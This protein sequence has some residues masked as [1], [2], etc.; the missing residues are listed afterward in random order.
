MVN[1]LIDLSIDSL[2]D[3]LIHSESFVFYCMLCYSEML[4]YSEERNPWESM[5]DKLT[6]IRYNIIH[7]LR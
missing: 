1:R 5:E 4:E 2:I 3:W 7:P 6:L